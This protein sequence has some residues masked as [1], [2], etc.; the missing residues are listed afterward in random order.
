[1]EA[2]GYNLNY[3]SCLHPAPTAGLHCGAQACERVAVLPAGA[4]TRLQT[5]GLHCGRW[6]MEA[7]AMCICT[8][9]RLQRPGSIAAGGWSADGWATAASCTP[10]QRPPLRHVPAGFPG[11]DPPEACT[12]LQTAGLH[13]GV[14]NPTWIDAMGLKLAP[15]AGGRAPFRLGYYQPV[16]P[17][18]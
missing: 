15:G 6:W 3:L 14:F 5:A 16:Q 12:R 4:R 10:L 8:C 7:E 17:E 11:P 2:Q 18:E 13:C 1:M 9:T